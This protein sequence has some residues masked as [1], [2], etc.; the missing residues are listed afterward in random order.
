MASARKKPRNDLP[1]RMQNNREKTARGQTDK[2]VERLTVASL[3]RMMPIRFVS[4]VNGNV[5]RIS[6]S[7]IVPASEM[8]QMMI[9]G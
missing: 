3:R 6:Y 8:K 9:I 4:L 1:A 5:L 7:S 2:Q